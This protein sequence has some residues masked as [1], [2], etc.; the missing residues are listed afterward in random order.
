MILAKGSI[1]ETGNHMNNDLGSSHSKV[2]SMKWGD[3]QSFL[4]I[5]YSQH[6]LGP[7]G[8]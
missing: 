8:S 5:N 6:A 2:Y 3:Y 7:H 4:Y 1:Q